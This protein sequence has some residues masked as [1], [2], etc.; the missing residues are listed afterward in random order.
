[1]LL[2]TC[3][4]FFSTHLLWITSLI[5]KNF[6]QISP[7][8]SMNDKSPV[9]ALVR[10]LSVCLNQ[11]TSGDRLRNGYKGRECWFVVWL[12]GGTF[13]MPYESS[14]WKMKN[15]VIMFFF[16]LFLLQQHT[17]DGRFS[18]YPDSHSSPDLKRLKPPKVLRERRALKVVKELKGL[19]R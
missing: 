15:N 6:V 19:M 2:D 14:S 17:P 8:R 16:Y 5:D 13:E 12:A 7:G 18:H 4:S 1:M 11:E 3:D 9:L 10:D